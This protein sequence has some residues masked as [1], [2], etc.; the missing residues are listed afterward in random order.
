MINVPVDKP[1]QHQ[2]HKVI[3]VNTHDLND[4]SIIRDSVMR[5]LKPILR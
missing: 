3:D 1:K 5:V 2:S 4:Y